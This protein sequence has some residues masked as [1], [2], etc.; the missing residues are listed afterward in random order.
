V[1][2]TDTFRGSS[3]CAPLKRFGHFIQMLAGDAPQ[4]RCCGT[5]PIIPGARAKN[6]RGIHHHG[7]FGA[8]RVC[9]DA[10][11]VGAV[12]ARIAC[13]HGTSNDR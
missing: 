13:F 3:L 7:Q 11:D 6:P 8:R 9:R 10:S 4:Q 2:A 1:S 5:G 12:H